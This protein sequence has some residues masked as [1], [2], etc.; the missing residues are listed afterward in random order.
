MQSPP[1]KPKY[2]SQL[3]LQGCPPV[4]TQDA[5]PNLS[6]ESVNGPLSPSEISTRMD[7]GLP[8]PFEQHW[9]SAGEDELSEVEADM[10]F[11]AQKLAVEHDAESDDDEDLSKDSDVDYER[12]QEGSDCGSD[13]I[14]TDIQVSHGCT[15]VSCGRSRAS[16]SSKTL[17]HKQG[18][19][20]NSE[21]HKKKRKSLSYKF[22]PLPHHPPILHLLTKHFCQ[23]PLL[24]ECHGQPHVMNVN[25][26]SWFWSE[27][28]SR[29]FVDI[30]RTSET[31]T[32]D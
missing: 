6:A 22:C 24:P 25:C 18:T 9:D 10:I 4:Y 11:Q 27:I 2:P 23:H 1:K 17:M 20:G 7:K 21:G 26:Q 19:K 12:D 28:G 15:R 14:T 3:L 5:T 13:Y 29:W 16:N 8:V 31:S 30:R 32:L